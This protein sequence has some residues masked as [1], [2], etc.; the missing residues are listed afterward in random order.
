M[1]STRIGILLALVAAPLA[2]QMPSVRSISLEDAIRLADRSSETVEIARAAVTRANGQ[3][4]MARSLFLPQLNA[5]A[6]YNKTLASQFDGFSLGGGASRST[7]ESV[8]APNIPAGA[9]ARFWLRDP[10]PTTDGSDGWV[11]YR[12]L[13]SSGAQQTVKFEFSDP[14]WWTDPNVATTSSNAFSF[15]TRSGSVTSAWS[16][17][18]VVKTDGHPFYVTFV[19]G[20]APLPPDA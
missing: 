10:K 6:A 11:R 17:R 3:Q 14:Y 15:Y 8:C 18:N 9:T 13:D 4:M 2:A 7:L 12:Y 1:R 16:S 20:N 5:S 19:W